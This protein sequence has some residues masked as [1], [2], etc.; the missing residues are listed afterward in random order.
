MGDTPAAIACGHVCLGA[1]PARLSEA[2]ALAIRASGRHIAQ[3]Q[4][5]GFQACSFAVPFE[6]GGFAVPLK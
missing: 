4:Q 3:L 5:A 6:Q 1:R 2:R